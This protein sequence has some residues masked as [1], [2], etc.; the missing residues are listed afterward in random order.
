MGTHESQHDPCETA[1]EAH[2][3]MQHVRVK[4]TQPN[5]H[6]DYIINM[7]QTPIPFAF[8]SKC[9]LEMVS[10]KTVH[11]QKSTT[12]TKRATLALTVTASGKMI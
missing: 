2:D 12:Y 3:Y 6:A 5:Q 4:L 1:T 7:D 10:K 9:T 8:N 11:I